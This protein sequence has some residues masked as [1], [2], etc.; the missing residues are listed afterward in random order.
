MDHRTCVALAFTL[1]IAFAATA[2][3]D[4]DPVAPDSDLRALGAA[5]SPTA[6]ATR[7]SF[8]SRNLYIGA[9]LNPVVAALASPSQTDDIPALINTITTIQNTG[10]PQRVVAIADEIER[11]RPQVIGLQE[12]WTLNINLVPL[13][14]NLVV[15][16]DFLT[17]LQAELAGRGLHYT[18]AATVSG[19]TANPNPFINVFDRDVLLVDPARVGVDPASIVSQTFAANIG[20]V[21]P[22]VIVRRGWVSIRAR[23]DGVPMTIANTHLEAETSPQLSALRA[24]QVG[25]IMASLADADPVVMLGDFNDLPGSPMH[26]TV[27]GAGFTDVWS[28]MRPGVE[29]LTCCHDKVLTNENSEGSFTMRI[30]YIFVRGLAH[31]N[32]EHLGSARL[33]GASPSERLVGSTALWASDHAGVVAD[34]LLPGH[35]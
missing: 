1:C 20:T 24:L 13:G 23:V 8:M 5:P 32:G 9:D 2:C 7:L 16:Q 22:G 15:D 18:V 11:D 25:Q 26:N 4:G 6:G 33:T 17:M 10:W 3:A 34:L 21:A 30:D 28:A 31:G 19:V 27:T 29:G 12:V 14:L 35:R